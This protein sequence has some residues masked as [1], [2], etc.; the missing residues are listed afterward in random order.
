MGGLH[1]QGMCHG[2]NISQTAIQWQGLRGA[3]YWESGWKCPLYCKVIL[4]M[5]PCLSSLNFG[6]S[7]SWGRELC[8]K[9]LSHLV[10][11]ALYENKLQSQLILLILSSLSVLNVC[12][13]RTSHYRVSPLFYHCVI[14]FDTSYSMLIV[15]LT[16]HLLC[17]E[18][19]NTCA[20]V[21]A[22][23]MY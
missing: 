22:L 3:G 17:P 8:I 2:E 9:E 10:L 4:A 5:I 16:G 23:C 12:F 19:M 15:L 13:S 21:V 11:P 6:L 7:V 18:L 14:L 1:A 20:V